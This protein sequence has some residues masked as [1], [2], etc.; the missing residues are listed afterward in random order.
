MEKNHD[1]AMFYNAIAVHTELAYKKLEQLKIHYGSWE[2]AWQS[3]AK[4][5]PSS[6]P[7]ELWAILEKNAVHCLLPEN[8]NYPSLLK[9]IPNAPLA[10]Y[11]RGTIEEINN[12]LPFAIVGTRKASEYGTRHARVFARSLA[13]KNSSIISGLAFG[14]DKAAHEGALEG[15]GHTVAVLAHGLDNVYPTSH[16][17]L[18]NKI[19]A[20]GGALI[21]EYPWGMASYPGNFVNRNRIISGISKGVLIIEAPSDSGALHTADCAANQGKDVFVIP[22][23]IDDPNY[24]G[25]HALIR[26]G[27]EFI[28]SPTHIMDAYGIEASHNLFS[29]I[30]KAETD[31]ATATMLACLRNA[32]TPLQIDK[33]AELTNLNIQTVLAIITIQ[34]LRH[35]IEETPNGIRLLT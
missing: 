24:Q 20:A 3:Q 17:G 1:E 5:F 25:S 21:S 28:T 6:S 29:E 2:L 27:A 15:H 4:L 23:H 11:V 31:P 18:A 22:G 10:L 14:I 13:E 26:D 19:L 9:E 34:I 35:T 32:G 16:E 33:I 8:P 12:K 7:E 30:P